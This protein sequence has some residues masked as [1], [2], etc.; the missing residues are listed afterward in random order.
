MGEWPGLNDDNIM[1]N[2]GLP[3]PLWAAIDGKLW[4]A[5]GPAELAGIIADGEIRV[6]RNRYTDS[7]AKAHDAVSLMDFGPNA[8]DK[9]QFCNWVGWMGDQQKS[10]VAVWLEINRTAVA[11]SLYDAGATLGLWRDAQLKGQLIPGIEACHRGP[12]SVTAIVSV[13][14]IDRYYDHSRFQ[15]CQM[16]SD[17]VEG[18]LADFF[19][20]LPAPPEGGFGAALEAAFAKRSN[21]TH[22]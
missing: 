16:N 11:A 18:P 4:H 14:L 20:G 5:T 22:S 3:A 9:D 21:G 7:L 8:T 1:N 10:R 13:I 12:I 2:P 19:R 6:F 17:V 15:P